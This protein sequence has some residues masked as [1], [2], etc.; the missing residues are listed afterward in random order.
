[1][2]CSTL[3]LVGLRAVLHVDGVAQ[4]DFVLQ[5]IRHSIPR[6]VIWALCIQPHV[7]DAVLAVGVH[8]R[9]QDMLFLE[10]AGNLAGAAA[11]GAHGKDPADDG[12]RL[13][14]HD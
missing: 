12:C 4:I 8:G 5:H 2:L 11:A 13:L 6:P 7:R 9:R 14:I 10:N 3:V 1:M